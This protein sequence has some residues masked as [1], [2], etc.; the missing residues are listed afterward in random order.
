MPL[1][2]ACMLICNVA[3]AYY[4]HAMLSRY[5]C[6]R[7]YADAA[8]ITL[9]RFDD[10]IFFAII[11]LILRCHAPAFAA[12]SLIRYASDERL[13]RHMPYI[14]HICLFY[15]MPFSDWRHDAAA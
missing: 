8:A 6:C 2:R 9:P 5:G 7:Y 15:A 11:S 13:C 10:D 1:P 12:F 14:C 3:A 4:A